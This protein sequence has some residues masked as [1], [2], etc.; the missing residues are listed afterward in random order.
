MRFRINHAKTY[1]GFC[2]LPFPR[3]CSADAIEGEWVCVT[4]LLATL[5]VV[6]GLKTCE[7]A[8]GRL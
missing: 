4:W 6:T 1:T 8:G 5:W 3:Y 2:N 7:K